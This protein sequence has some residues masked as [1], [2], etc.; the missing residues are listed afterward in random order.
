[1]FQVASGGKYTCCV[2]FVLKLFEQ[3]ILILSCVFKVK[4]DFVFTYPHFLQN[5]LFLLSVLSNI[6]M[7]SILPTAY[8]MVQKLHHF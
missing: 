3:I 6:Y 7:K 5:R 2:M 4:T 1:M 8:R